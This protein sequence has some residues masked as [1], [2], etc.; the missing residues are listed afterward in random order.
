MSQLPSHRRK[1]LD[2]A[3]SSLS[4]RRQLSLQTESRT[5]PG[6][7]PDV[8]HTLSSE[9]L[10]GTSYFSS[11]SRMTTLE[12]SPLQ[13][14][15]LPQRAPSGSRSPV[16]IYYSMP[17]SPISRYPYFQNP[18]APITPAIESTWSAGSQQSF[19]PRVQESL[20]SSEYIDR[21][22]VVSPGISNVLAGQFQCPICE[23]R[24]FVPRD[25]GL[26]PL[27]KPSDSTTRLSM[28]V[29]ITS[30][31]RAYHTTCLTC[32]SCLRPFDSGH[33]D[34]SAW[35]FIGPASPYHSRC[36]VDGSKP[37]LERLKQR[38]RTERGKPVIGIHSARG[39]FGRAHSSPRRLVS[40]WSR[41]NTGEEGGSPVMTKV[42]N[43][44]ELRQFPTKLE[45]IEDAKARPKKEIP[46]T[47][48]G[49]QE[50]AA[51]PLSSTP[52]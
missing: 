36:A 30:S 5:C 17:S 16:S 37:I 52:L 41:N 46:S 10:E 18:R 35:T 39:G 3:T 9:S 21:Y 13:T 29:V 51:F 49:S 25:E 44:I 7:S 14:P 23:E 12:A 6:P 1:E 27:I 22:N 19:S 26:F 2:P 47:L 11:R 40:A 8:D 33:D 15:K 32:R 45:V 24:I 31:G 48:D 50:A 4:Q 28:N 42:E 38:L 34:I 20:S 43:E